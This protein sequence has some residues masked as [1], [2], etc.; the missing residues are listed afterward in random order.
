MSFL[1]PLNNISYEEKQFISKELCIFQDNVKKK[2]KSSSLIVMYEMENDYV[3]LPFA[4][5]MKHYSKFVNFNEFQKVNF[6]MNIQLR[7]YQ[8]E[9]RQYVIDILKHQHSC[10][11]A[12]H[13]GWG[14]SIFALYLISKIKL[15][16][17]IIVKGI[18][19]LEQWKTT[20]ETYCSNK[21]QILNSKSKIG[22]DNDIYL[23]NCINVSKF[24]LND[25]K[26][27]GNVICDEIHLLTAQIMF[28]AFFRLCPK[29]FIGLSATPYRPDGLDVIID[30]YF[31]TEK[32]IV[33]L[34]QDHSVYPVYTQLKIKHTLQWDGSINW[35]SVLEA[36]ANNEKRNE[37]IISIIKSYSSRNFLVLCKRV[38]HGEYLYD[39]LIQEKQ[40]ATM[41]LGTIRDFDREA[42]I[43]ICTPQKC[44]TG[45]SH[46]KLDAL[47]V[48]SDMEEYF[49]Q[50][51]GRVFRNPSTK[52][53][54]FDIIDE[55]PVL[56]KHFETRKDIYLSS[57]GKL[58]Q[59]S[60]L[61]L[62]N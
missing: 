24:T 19:L 17:L 59:F 9:K 37:L 44:G 16:T 7:D 5:T 61:L 46:N 32:L 8:E 40:D 25:F 14:K 33:K 48:A 45:F 3:L 6:D 11:L 54:I 34:N 43:L 20:I 57:G 50:Y 62:K 35:H 55:H 12:L 28:K 29:Y 60:R 41:L 38:E 53:V 49:I 4:F 13:V 10:I 39:T 58:C 56:K 51:L 22:H 36:Q 15:K 23:I 30:T 2:Q 52:P 42:R 31:G 27:I 47:I 26:H 18:V 1:V 21:V